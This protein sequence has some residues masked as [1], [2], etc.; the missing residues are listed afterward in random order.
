MRT[1][2]SLPV[3]TQMNTPVPA[4]ASNKDLRERPRK[5]LSGKNSRWTAKTRNRKS[6]HD[7][8]P[9]NQPLNKH[10]SPKASNSLSVVNKPRPK[11]ILT[12]PRPG[13]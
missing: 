12:K 11:L 8:R 7:L 4:R 13:P 5:K 2:L 10:P 6:Q 1:R 3:A 9:Y